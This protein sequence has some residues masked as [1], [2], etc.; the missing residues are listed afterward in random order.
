MAI[1]LRLRAWKLRF[2]HSQREFVRNNN[3]TVPSKADGLLARITNRNVMETS[4]NQLFDTLFIISCF[5]SR[6]THTSV[7][8]TTPGPVAEMDAPRS[9][10]DDPRFVE[11]AK[12]PFNIRVMM[13]DAFVGY[14]SDCHEKAGQVL[15]L[16]VCNIRRIN[17]KT[18]YEHRIIVSHWFRND[19]CLGLYDQNALDIISNYLPCLEVNR[20]ELWHLIKRYKM[21]TKFGVCE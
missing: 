9:P 19:H 21:I 4:L 12:F 11:F 20:K 10:L 16:I 5:P 14:G 15:D 1:Q 2:S 3:Y 17:Q 7:D 18:Q 13:D 8:I 6:D